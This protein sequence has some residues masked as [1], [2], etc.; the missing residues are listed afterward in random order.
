[1]KRA[2]VSVR[3]GT[4]NHVFRRRLVGFAGALGAARPV[5]RTPRAA[6]AAQDGGGEA[7]PNGIDVTR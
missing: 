4:Q 6:L 5:G 1:M 2:L 3:E 7:F